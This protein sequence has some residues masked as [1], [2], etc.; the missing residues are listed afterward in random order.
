MALSLEDRGS[1]HSLR[2]GTGG[3]VRTWPLTARVALGSRWSAAWLGFPACRSG[4]VNKALLIILS[5]SPG[6]ASGCSVL[7]VAHRGLER[8]VTGR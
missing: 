5:E 7:R 1:Q 2:G 8:L 4:R 3:P 6:T